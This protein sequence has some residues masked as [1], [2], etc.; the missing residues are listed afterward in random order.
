MRG[1]V[2][3]DTS[4]AKTFDSLIFSLGNKQ[5]SPMDEICDVEISLICPQPWYTHMG[6][7]EFDA[8]SE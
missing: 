7:S 1:R 3:F 8:T 4:S 2:I 5:K 6:D